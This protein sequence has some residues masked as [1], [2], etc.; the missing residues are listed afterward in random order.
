MAWYAADLSECE[1][2]CD[3]GNRGGCQYNH[4]EAG[5]LHKCA[6]CANG[7]SS[8]DRQECGRDLQNDVSLTCLFEISGFLL[9]RLEPY[10]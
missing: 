5:T 7:C 8:T 2:H 4:P 1:G 9:D 10:L 3:V 6:T